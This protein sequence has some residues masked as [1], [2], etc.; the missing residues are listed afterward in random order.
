VT[1]SPHRRAAAPLAGAFLGA[2]LLLLSGCSA[3][4]IAE[5]ANKEAS[6]QGVDVEAE[7]DDGSVAV[8]N[9]MVAYPGPEGYESGEDAPVEVWI[10]NDTRSEVTV[11]VRPGAVGDDADALVRVASVEL[12]D[13]DTG[14]A[15]AGESPAAGG[16]PAARV[17]ISAGGYSA[18]TQDNGTYLRLV[19]L[20]STLPA[21]K[22]V[23]LVFEFSNGATIQVEAPVAAPLTPVPR[24]TPEEEELQGGH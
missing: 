11:T 14:A 12:V 21:G 5:T 8:R 7:V 1:R 6:V 15:G 3:G 24:A 20:A 10:F 22:A 2:A 17:E 9:A 13:G 23:P 18:L 4:Q 16:E 19:D